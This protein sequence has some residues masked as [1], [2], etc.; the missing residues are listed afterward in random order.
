MCHHVAKLG[1][2][3]PNIANRTSFSAAT[4]KTR[5]KWNRERLRCTNAFIQACLSSRNSGFLKWQRTFYPWMAAGMSNKGYNLC[6]PLNILLPQKLNPY[7]S[8]GSSAFLVGAIISSRIS[9][10]LHPAV[11]LQRRCWA[12][13]LP[14]E[15]SWLAVWSR[16]PGAQHRAVTFTH[17]STRKLQFQKHLDTYTKIANPAV[18]GSVA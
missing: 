10:E 12:T 5:W 18:F 7:V 9:E 13:T 2:K 14:N 11:R 6:T 15:S 4:L 16:L 3:H 1:N 17:S 8:S